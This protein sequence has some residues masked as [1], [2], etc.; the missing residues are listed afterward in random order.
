M[1]D[2]H[3]VTEARRS[4]KQIFRYGLVGVASNLVGYFLF[5]LITYWGAEPKKAMTLLYVVGATIGFVG[6]RQ[7]AFAHNG[8]L[9]GSGL[10]YFTAHLCGYLINLIIL[11]TFVDKLGYSHQWVQAVAIIV[12]AGFLYLSFKYFVFP[13]SR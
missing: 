12:V 3:I 10:K 5:L 1:N 4:L 2:S 13:K 8:A 9:I 7:W 11:L 6:N